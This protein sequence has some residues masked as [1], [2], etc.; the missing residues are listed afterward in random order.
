M[1]ET[2]K[3]ANLGANKGKRM[4]YIRSTDIER[5]NWK[6]LL[7]SFPDEALYFMTLGKTI[8]IVDKSKH[9]QGDVERIFCP[10]MMDFLRVIKRKRFDED[11]LC[12]PQLKDHLIEALSV[13]GQNKTIHR[14]YNFFK[15]KIKTLK[16]IGKTIKCSKEPSVWIK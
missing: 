10:V 1:G 14:K 6:S 5:V 7:M 4:M 3:Y 8:E 16:I 12:F 11:E 15:N 13:Y 2:I 9:K